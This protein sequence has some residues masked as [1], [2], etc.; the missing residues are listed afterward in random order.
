MSLR[1]VLRLRD[2]ELRSS[3]G[4]QVEG[5]LLELNMKWPVRGRVSLREVGSDILTFE[6]VMKQQVYRSI[7]T[8]LPHCETVIDLGANIGLASL[9]F[10]RQYPSCRL[11]AVEPNPDTYRMLT[12][13]L[14]ELVEQGRCRTVNAA[15]WGSE[16]MLVADGAQDPEHYSAFATKEANPG[17]RSGETMKGLPVQTIINDS[18]FTKIDLLKVDIEG[19]EVELFKGD[20]AWLRNVNSIAIEFHGASRKECKFDELSRDY[21]FHIH[22]QEAHT[23]L[24]VRNGKSVGR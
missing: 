8:K 16:K 19:A 17:E 18:G 22:D 20:L 2:Y 10:A 14:G 23:V 12:T 7:L 24:A 11:V 1:S 3:K 21:G 5:R 4:K 15:V 13:N 9:Y 6:E